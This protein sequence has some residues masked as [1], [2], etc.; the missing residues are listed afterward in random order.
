MRLRLLRRRLSANSPR[1][2]IRRATPWPLRWLL[3]AVVLGFSAALALW[4]FEFGKEIAG[5]ERHAPEELRQLREQV[6]SLSEALGRAESISNTADSLLTAEKVALEELARQI[7]QLQE[8]NQTLRNDLGFF[9]RLIPG[10]GGDGLRIR[11][12]QAQQVSDTQVQ[13]QVLMIQARKNAPDFQG[14]LELVASGTAPDGQPWRMSA[15]ETRPVRVQGYLRQ[16]GVMDVPPGVVV[17][18]VTA[19]LRKGS[20]VQSEQIINL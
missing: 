11:G 13:W 16:E 7:R 9:E 10:S 1:L 20:A 17:K 14:A 5:V 2:A 12:L 8:D 19:R 6:R 4:A 15:P 18:T 3:G